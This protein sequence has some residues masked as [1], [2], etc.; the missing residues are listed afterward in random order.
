MVRLGIARSVGALVLCVIASATII[1]GGGVAVS[2]PD[3][4]MQIEQGETLSSYVRVWN[5]GSTTREFTVQVE[6]NCSQIVNVLP[7]GFSLGPG[8]EKL[9]DIDYAAP[10][11]QA[12][13]IYS[14]SITVSVEG[15]ISSSVTRRVS[16]TV[17]ARG[18]SKLDLGS[19]TNLVG[20]I[21]AD[22]SFGDALGR[23]AGPT[24]VWTR[25]ADGSYI[26][27]QYY[28]SAGIWWSRDPSF[29]GLEYG[30]AYF[31]EC[32]TECNIGYAPGGGSGQ[33]ALETGTNLIVWTGEDRA[34][35]RAFPQGPQ[36][37]S[38]TKVWRRT[39]D[40]EYEFAQYYPSADSWWSRDPTFNRLEEGEAY[41]VESTDQVRI[42]I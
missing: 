28:P 25:G 4:I 36:E 26:S 41:F 27:A 42:S 14:G 12:P 15:E 18:T 13:G 30:R 9:V 33:L 35:E 31:I 38:V 24:K 5:E 22:V 32:E 8:G 37:Y 19:G 34:L 3:Q 10:A 17:L 40:G 7:R 20:W 6:G 21:G 29:T 39:G 16:V 11:D 23:G 1:T 2:G